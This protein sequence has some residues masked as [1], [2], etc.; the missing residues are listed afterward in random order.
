MNYEYEYFNSWNEFLTHLESADISHV[1]DPSS[2]K[3]SK[4]EWYGTPS[5]NAAI[6]LARSGDQNH[7]PTVEG[8]VAKIMPTLHDTV[9]KRN[10]YKWSVTGGSVNV[11][12]MMSGDPR[13]MRKR[14][15]VPSAIQHKALRISVP[16]Q[17][18]AR[19]HAP[20]IIKTGAAIVALTKL[21]L[22]ANYPVEIVGTATYNPTNGQRD[23]Q[24]VTDVVLKR[25]DETLD[26]PKLLMACAH[27]SS[28]RRLGFR[29]MESWTGDKH[30]R[31]IS[32]YGLITADR[33]K[34]DFDIVISG[35]HGSY[36]RIAADPV[37]WITKTL[38]ELGVLKESHQ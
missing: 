37:G 29:L 7:M 34:D 22:N 31:Y 8:L 19:E 30:D 1:D 6:E 9:A 36:N 32:S 23:Y 3:T 11:G 18:S 14:V 12:R 2:L 27:P 21:L 10:S 33:P 13:A 24:A 20:N 28:F 35:V 26:I 16:M 25:S 17:W 4:P 15:K 38:G 5:F